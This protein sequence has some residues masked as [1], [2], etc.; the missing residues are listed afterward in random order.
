MAKSIEKRI[1]IIEKE[2]AA[3]KA[4]CT[5]RTPAYDKIA[6]AKCEEHYRTV[7]GFYNNKTPYNICIEMARAAFKDKRGIA[8]QGL[9]PFEYIKTLA[10]ADELFD[11]FKR[12]LAEYVRYLSERR[13]LRW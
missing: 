12:F 6:T 5:E 8:H 10:D 4:T 3:L 13:Y 2:V 11:I 1:E 9:K 7:A